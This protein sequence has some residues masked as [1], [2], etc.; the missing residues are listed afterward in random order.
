MHWWLTSSGAMAAETRCCW[1]LL[2]LSWY[3]DTGE[4]GRLVRDK[5]L[6]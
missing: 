1:R 2:R 5:V 6:T 4:F 3:I